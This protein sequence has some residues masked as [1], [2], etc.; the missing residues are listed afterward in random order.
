MVVGFLEEGG[1]KITLTEFAQ[2]QLEELREMQKICCKNNN[3]DQYIEISKLML[4]I[5]DS[6]RTK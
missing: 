5:W 3:M 1:F 2:K 4:Q 6:I